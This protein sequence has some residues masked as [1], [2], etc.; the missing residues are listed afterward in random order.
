MANAPHSKTEVS[1][2]RY[3]L[4][5]AEDYVGTEDWFGLQQ[6]AFQILQ[7]DLHHRNT[8]RPHLTVVLNREPGDAA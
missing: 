3:L 4:T 6:T 5:H 7:A 1:Q 8:A 2:A